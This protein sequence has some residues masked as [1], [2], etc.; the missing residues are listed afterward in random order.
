MLFRNKKNLFL[1]L[2]SGCIFWWM[3]S[4]HLFEKKEIDH[5]C[6]RCMN[7]H[8]NNQSGRGIS[9][10]KLLSKIPKDDQL[11]LEDFFHDLI[12][13]SLF[14]YVLFGNKPLSEA[15]CINPLSDF[16]FQ[17][18]LDH[19]NLKFHKGITCWKKY[20]HLFSSE[21]YLFNFFG[22]AEKDRSITIALINK[23]EYLKV[24]KKNLSKFQS[25]FGPNMTAEKLLTKFATEQNFFENHFDCEM[26]GILF[27]YGEFNSYLFQRRADIDPDPY[28]CSRFILKKQPKIP[29]QGYATLE[30]EFADLNIQLQSL[31]DDILFDQGYMDLPRFKA[32][33]SEETTRIKNDFIQTRKKMIKIF[34][35]GE[36]FKKSMQRYTGLKSE[37]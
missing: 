30:E 18:R 21:D 2:I 20:C 32:V 24:V 26:L 10:S 31:E 29:R 25:V 6:S 1:L 9:L 19:E 8:T 12:T 11:I 28:C 23:K 16:Y 35:D 13:Q 22:D 33:D 36:F 27:G 17:F 7:L 4:L 14:G 5:A 37:S 15:G 34:K 3:F